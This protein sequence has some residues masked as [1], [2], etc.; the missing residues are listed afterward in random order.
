[1]NY[2][3]SALVGALLAF[4]AAWQVQDWRYGE[5]IFQ[6]R[7]DEQKATSAAYGRALAKTAEFQR[8][9]DEALNAANQRAQRQA[10]AAASARADAV[11]L[12]DQLAA[13]R[14]DLSHAS[15]D[16]AR[17]YAAA[18]ST[19]FAECTGALAEMAGAADGHAS[20]SLMYQQAW[21]AA[22]TGPP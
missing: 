3:I 14:A 15:L 16:A 19:V 8:K 17:R 20:D 12:R 13:A 1:M 18:L 2:L 21:P 5:Q 11:S 9:K 7:Y 10:S 22:S 4:A 6:I